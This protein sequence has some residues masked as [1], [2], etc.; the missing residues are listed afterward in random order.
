MGMFKRVNIF[1]IYRYGLGTKLPWDEQFVIESLSDSTIYNAFYTI[2]HILTK[3]SLNGK[4]ESIKYD[5]SSEDLT[6]EV[7]DYVFL[8]KDELPKD[9]KIPTELLV[10]M[11]SEFQYWY[12]VDIRTSGKDLIQNHLTMYLYNHIAIFDDKKKWP[13]GIFANGHV[14]V[15]GEKMSKSLGNFLIL[16]QTINNY[17][18]DAT[19]IALADSGDGLEDANFETHT[20]DIQSVK[21]AKHIDWVIEVVNEYKKTE[22]FEE[23]G[24][25]ETVFIERIKQLTQLAYGSYKNMKFRDSL[26]HSWFDF[27]Q[28]R[29]DYRV[30]SES[31]MNLKVLM[32][33]IETQTIIMEPIT[34]HISNYIWRVVLGKKEKMLWPKFENEVNH[35]ILA[36]YRFFQTQLHAFRTKLIKETKQKLAAP[37]SAIIHV[38]RGYSDIQK[39]VLGIMRDYLKE[40]PVFS[41]KDISKEVSKKYDKKQTTDVMGFVNHVGGEYEKYSFEALTEALPFE[42]TKIFKSNEKAILSS[43]SIEKIVYYYIDDV[44]VKDPGNRIPFVAFGKPQ[45]TFIRE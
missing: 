39:D 3:G 31:K 35:K 20:A 24:F 41:A 33:F 13:K 17:S 21:L 45:I 11:K 4:D 26:K 1:I 9:S 28:L 19:R 32:E 43:L 27:Q 12:P 40:N 36:S 18:A 25:N 15:N 16:D 5:L 22:K 2:S 37:K 42:E 6:K 30:D 38:V 10:K 44:D 7:F 14:M 29:D 23:Y 34:P 8:D